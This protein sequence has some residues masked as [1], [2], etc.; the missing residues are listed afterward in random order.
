MSDSCT[1][2]P[3]THVTPD[4]LLVKCY[5]K[6]RAG[7]V[8]LFSWQFWVATTLGFPLEHAL[9]TKIPFLRAIAQWAGL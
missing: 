4:G 2:V 9:W 1:S 7:V 6:C 3:H 8:S 5:H